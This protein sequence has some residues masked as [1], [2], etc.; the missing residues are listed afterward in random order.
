[1]AIKNK[2]IEVNGV[3]VTINFTNQADFISLTDIARFKNLDRTDTIIQNWLRNRN[4]IEL[5]GFWEQLYNP[6]FKPIEFDG[7]R[8]QAGL[9]SFTLT[10]K[11]WVEKTE[12]IGIV[13]K[14]GKFG[15]TFAHKDIAFEFASWIS[16]EFK[17]YLIKEFQR[18]KD[19][20]SERLKL[21][22]NL[23]RTLAK[24][25][26]HIHTDAIK[27]NLIPTEIYKNK[28]PL[29]YASEADILNVALF[30]I[31][32]KQ[33]RDKNSEENGNIRDQA[34]LEQLVVLSNLESINAILINQG[35]SQ[36]DRLIQLNQIAITQMKSLLKSVAL[37]KLKSS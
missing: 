5:L 33:W 36:S 10:P 15:G 19:D 12:A 16:I 29:V 24:V 30:G 34:T 27:E 22:W 31:T 35:L 23:Q 20:E 14:A 28:I 25:N 2:C 17:L 21:D 26:Y 3:K 4:T 11:Q 32:A 13:S 37:K 1:M 6:N 8:K 18:L 7:F 9:N